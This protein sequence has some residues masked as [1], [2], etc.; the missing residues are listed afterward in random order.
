MLSTWMCKENALSRKMKAQ[1][2]MLRE[3]ERERPLAHNFY[4]SIV[5]LLINLL[6]RMICK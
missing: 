4:Y 6:L 3:T 2:D 5:I 1:L